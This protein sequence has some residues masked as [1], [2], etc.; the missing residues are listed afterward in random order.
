MKKPPYAHVGYAD[1][2]LAT[3]TGTE[4]F[5]V[6]R[7]KRITPTTDPGLPADCYLTDKQWQGVVDLV[8]S[9]P[10]LS[11]FSNHPQQW[12]SPRAVIEYCRN[13]RDPFE[14]AFAIV[15][16]QTRHAEYGFA[17]EV[18]ALFDTI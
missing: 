16:D 2:K 6:A 7:L 3:L 11:S 14:T 18:L 10:K 15:S 13:Q 9:A 8:N 1:Q 5:D 4:G 17:A 12:E